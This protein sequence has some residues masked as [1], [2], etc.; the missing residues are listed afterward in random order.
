MDTKQAKP[1]IKWAGGKGQLLPEIQQM[2]SSYMGK[3]YTKYVEPFVGGGAVLFD[4]LNKFDIESVY[5]SDL[6]RELILT[7]KAIQKSVHPLI[8]RLQELQLLNELDAAGRKATYYEKRKRFNELKSQEKLSEEQSIECAS[9]LI[10]LNKTCFNG[11]Y[12]VNKKGEFNVPVG[13]YTNPTICDT[14]NLLAV[15]EKL[16][17]VHISCASYE[18]SE[19]VIDEN[20]FVYIDPPYRIIGTQANFTSYTELPFDNDAQEALVDFVKRMD[21]KG[22][23][24]LLSNSDPTNFGIQDDFFDTRFAGCEIKRVY[25]NRMINS[26]SSERGK[27]S[28]LLIRM[29]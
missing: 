9:L 28:E 12:R 6:N 15:S 3:I 5:I 21:E 17:N 1:F 27:I 22:A 18:M 29:F 13:S 26:K 8:A 23:A 24:I 2:Y 19:S 11:L 20:T 4:V 7:Y 10:Y 25:A 16:Q 14:D